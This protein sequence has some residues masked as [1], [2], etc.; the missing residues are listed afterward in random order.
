MYIAKVT[1]PDDQF[2]LCELLGVDEAS[3][4]EFLDIF[5]DHISGDVSYTDAKPVMTAITSAVRRVSK[6]LAADIDNLSYN[7]KQILLFWECIKGQPDTLVEATQL[8][9][10][11]ISVC[12]DLFVNTRR[13]EYIPVRV[14][15]YGLRWV[16]DCPDTQFVISLRNSWSNF[17]TLRKI[18]AQRSS[19]STRGIKT[20]EFEETPA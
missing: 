12:Y 18:Y 17:G 11:R 10:E 14:T 2:D 6:K 15:C 13:L 20:P 7:E 5:P 1:D 3:K 9:I 8:R 19:V 4:P 16:L